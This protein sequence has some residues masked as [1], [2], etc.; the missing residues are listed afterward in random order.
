[1]H[2]I[3]EAFRNPSSVSP[4][5]AGMLSVFAFPHI[6]GAQSLKRLLPVRTPEE[7]IRDAWLAVGNDLRSAM[8]DYE[9]ESSGKKG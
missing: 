6:G 3:I 5:L 8:Q 2:S 7:D 4:F 1:M 9:K